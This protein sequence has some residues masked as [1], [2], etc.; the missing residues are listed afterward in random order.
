MEQEEAPGRHQDG[1]G[2]IGGDKCD[3]RGPEVEN[4]PL[5]SAAGEAL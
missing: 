1:G 3:S 2:Q 5:W 4:A